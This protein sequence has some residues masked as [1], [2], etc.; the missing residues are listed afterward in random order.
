MLAF[1]PNHVEVYAVDDAAV[2]P[3]HQEL[4]VD[5]VVLHTDSGSGRPQREPWPPNVEGPEG[6]VR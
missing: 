5:A 3:H 1:Y 4:D 2:N 6:G